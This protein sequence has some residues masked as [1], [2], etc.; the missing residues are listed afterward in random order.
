L[1]SFFSLPCLGLGSAAGAGLSDAFFEA[2]ACARELRKSSPK[3]KPRSNWS[4]C[5]NKFQSVYRQDP[6]G[7]WAPASLFHSGVL[8]M[9]LYR[10]FRNDADKKAAADL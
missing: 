3:I 1:A 6:K 8:Y 10:V 2:E 9:E 4:E 7:P 5:I